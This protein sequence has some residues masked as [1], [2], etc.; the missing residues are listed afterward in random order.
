MRTCG[1]A[2]FLDLKMT[3]PNYKRNTHPNSNLTLTLTLKNPNLKL[4]KIV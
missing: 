2:D 1:S 3:K 4:L